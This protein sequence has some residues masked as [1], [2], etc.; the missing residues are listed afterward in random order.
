MKINEAPTFST[1][2]KEYETEKKQLATSEGQKLNLAT[3]FPN[4]LMNDIARDQMLVRERQ[5][6][7][8][9]YFSNPI[10]ID[11]YRRSIEYSS[12]NGS[13]GSPTGEYEA[14]F[15]NELVVKGEKFY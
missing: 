5:L 2:D 8:D 7:Y 1:V 6:M 13:R 4:P 15:E 12:Y 3:V 14:E 9:Q 10:P 11:Y